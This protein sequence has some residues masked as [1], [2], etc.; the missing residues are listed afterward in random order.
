MKKV[1]NEN[2][3][4]FKYIIYLLIFITVISIAVNPSTRKFVSLLS[5]INK[6][7]KQ[8]ETIKNENETYKKRLNKLKTN[9]REMEKFAKISVGN[10]NIGVLA[11]TEIEYIF[12]DFD[13]KTEE[14]NEIQ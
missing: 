10:P 9:P 7:E 3:D 12:E 11:E 2:N 13:K 4:I 5:N 6:L 1:N 8:V 14:S